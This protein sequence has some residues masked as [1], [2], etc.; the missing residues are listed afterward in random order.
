L[1]HRACVLAVRALAS[2]PDAFYA[3]LARIPAW[4]AQAFEA[5]LTHH[6]LRAWAAP[7]LVGERARPFVGPAF[8]NAL[9]AYQ[10]GRARRNEALLRE[11]VAVRS[12]LAEAG[13]GCLFLKGLYVGHRFYGD[14]NRR[15]Q[16]D[17]DVLVRSR[18]FEAAL[19]A[20]ARL[21]FDVS[22]NLDDGKPV[23]QRLREIRGRTPAKAPHGVK[24]RRGDTSVDLHWCLNS[25][26]AS[27]VVE[28]SLWDARQRF[29][30]AGHELETLCDEHGLAFLLVSLCEDLRRGACRAKH[31]L[32]LYLMLRALEPRLDWEALFGEQRRQGVLKASVNVLAVFLSLW[33]CAPELPDLVRALRRRLRLVELRDAEEALALVERP[34]G[35]AENRLWFR[36][37]YPRSPSRYWAF[38]LTQDLPHTLARL[39]PSRAFA[40][41]E[42]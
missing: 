41:P 25:R 39:Q 10:A 12:A 32:D 13:I 33:G 6:Q 38:R 5:F 35:S 16:A 42:R 20:L 23:A 37:V 8:R 30:L 22:T 1:E 17:V 27:R 15:H 34:R 29:L 24:V 19:A 28:D 4:D 7:A 3:A 40:L 9:I 14:V 21:G 18:D 2:G 11:S 26:S 31:L 36:R